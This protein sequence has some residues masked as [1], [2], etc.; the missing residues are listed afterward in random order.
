MIQPWNG[1]K[2][3]AR[4]PLV[5]L[6]MAYSLFSLALPPRKNCPR[7]LPSFFHKLCLR[8]ISCTS[9]FAL[10]VSLVDEKQVFHIC[11]ESVWEREPNPTWLV[12]VV[13]PCRPYTSDSPTPRIPTFSKL[14][15]FQT[16]YIAIYMWNLWQSCFEHLLTFG[17]I[18]H[19]ESALW[20]CFFKICGSSLKEAFSLHSCNQSLAVPGCHWEW[21]L[22]PSKPNRAAEEGGY[23]S[24]R[25]RIRS[26]A[27]KVKLSV[28]WFRCE[29]GAKLW[30][31]CP[32]KLQMFF[33]VKV[34]K[35]Q[36]Q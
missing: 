12:F 16:S 17:P 9:A 11:D 18:F 14:F 13:S 8:Q 28:H 7:Q 30:L 24:V 15:T 33:S 22:I 3:A 2:E 35:F 4:R 5:W 21:I 32:I 25:C 29:F 26:I 31:N 34:A 20:K 19:R 23:T 1:W 6:A 10:V 36:R 27:L